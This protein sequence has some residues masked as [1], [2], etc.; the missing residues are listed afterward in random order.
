MCLVCNKTL[1]FCKCEDLEKR[2]DPAVDAGRFAYRYCKKCKKHY[3]RCRCAHPAWGIKGAD[4]EKILRPK[5]I[6]KL[7][8]GSQN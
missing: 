6:I 3:E 2:L 1:H 4:E 5:R 7:K 8:N